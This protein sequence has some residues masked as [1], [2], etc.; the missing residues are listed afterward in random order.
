MEQRR[1]RHCELGN[2]PP[3]PQVSKIEHGVR[4]QPTVTAELRHDVVVGEV[5]VDRLHRQGVFDR[6]QC[7]PRDV[8][9]VH[10]RGP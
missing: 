9:G 1:H 4:V 7:G 3:A 5:A 2:T 10:H 8:S 6:G